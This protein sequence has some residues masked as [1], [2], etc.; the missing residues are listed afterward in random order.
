LILPSLVSASKLGNTSP[1]FILAGG[2]EIFL[3]SQCLLFSRQLQ[4]LMLS[5][6][7]AKGEGH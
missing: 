6:E 5:A 2:W 3:F 4:L 1:S 7:Q